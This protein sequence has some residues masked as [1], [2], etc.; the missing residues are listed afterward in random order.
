VAVGCHEVGDIKVASLQFSGN[1]A[2]KDGALADVMETRASGRFPWSRHYYFDQAT[3]EQDLDRLIAFYHDRGFPDARIESVD[4]DLSPAKDS[5]R[6]AIDVHEGDPLLVERVEFTGLDALATDVREA[7]TDVPLKAGQ[8]RDRADV[9]TSREQMAFRLSDHG[10]PRARVKASERPGATSGTIVVSFAVEPGPETYYGATSVNGAD[11]VEPA[12]IRRS[13][14][15]QPGELYRQSRVLESQRR[16]ASLGVFDFAHIAPAEPGSGAEAPARVT[17]PMTITVTEGQPQ[18]YQLGLGYGSEDGPRGSIEFDHLNFLGGA[19]QFRATARYSARLRGVGVDFSQPYLL[20]R[21]LSLTS[22]GDH[23]WA[24]EPT[25]TSRTRGGQVTLVLREERRRGLDLAPVSTSLRLSYAL[26]QVRYAIREE[27]L[28]DLT[29]FDELIALGLDPVEGSG[30]GRL[31]ALRLQFGRQSVNVPGDPTLGYTVTAEVGHA[32]SWVGGT[33]RYDEIDAQ[34]VGY[35]PLGR[36]VWA[37]RVRAASLFARDS[38]SVPFSE[39]YFL[40]GSTSMRGW[41]RFQVAPLTTDGLPIGGRALLDISSELRVPVAGSVG[42]VAFVDA[43]Q[44][45]ADSA[46]LASSPLLLAAGPGIRWTSPV[47]IVRA[48]LGIQ[49]RRIAG[50]LVDGAPERRRWRLHFSIGHTF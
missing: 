20:T 33:F 36:T 1:E 40:G 22:R 19:R 27:V 10:Y 16:L 26:D 44:V 37:T 2:F 47:G 50:L 23:W 25:Y 30:S 46:S 6:L 41:G 34:A 17:V 39:R 45:W 4:V 32:A 24:S 29:Q 11:A 31:G 3:F 7:V 38:A 28:D 42:L 35:L 9:A 5:V 13:V 15:F 43:G 48:D 18:R 8:P 14:L 12:V 21:R 49:L